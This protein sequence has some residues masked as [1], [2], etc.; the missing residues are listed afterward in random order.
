[1]RWEQTVELV[2]WRRFH[3]SITATVC[4]VTSDWSGD[5]GFVS[6][7]KRGRDQHKWSGTISKNLGPPLVE[8]AAPDGC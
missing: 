1:M 7:M 6:G 5:V 3:P 8:M 4:R 2:R